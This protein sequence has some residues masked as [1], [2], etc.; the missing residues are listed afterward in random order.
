[1]SVPLCLWSGPRNISTAMMRSFGAR[2]DTLVWDEPF[3]AAFL[4]RTGLSHP[5]RD[6]TLAQCE[7]EADIVAAQCVAEVPA[8]YHFQKHMAHHMV[9]GMPLA[10]VANARHA[11]LV[12]RPERVIASYARGRPDFTE[13]DLGYGRLLT[14]RDELEALTGVRPR[15]FDSDAVLADPD[16]QLRALCGALAIPFDPA[17]LSWKAEPRPEDGPWAPHWYASV[18]RSTG[19]A[20]PPADVPNV[21]PEHAA[22]FEACQRDYAALLAE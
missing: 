7:T 21:A 20:P 6:E 17:M 1:M 22:L 14:L 10:W 19:F 15:V 16:G 8:R 11:L 5:G 18:V 3:F 2:D 9:P 12:R 13:A 4:H